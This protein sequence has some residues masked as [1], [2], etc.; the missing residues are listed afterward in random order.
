MA[1][2]VFIFKK[3]CDDTN[4]V[5]SV[6]IN[7]AHFKELTNHFIP[8]P[9][10]LNNTIEA[11]L[12]TMG[13]AARLHDP[14]PTFC[15]CRNSRNRNENPNFDSTNSNQQIIIADEVFQCPDCL[16]MFCLDC[17]LYVHETVHNCPGCV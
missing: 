9:P 16:N 13:F 8:P 12:M 10:I 7:E 14:T 17:D 5:F 4:G 11:H 1:A 2:E 3:V 15:S 6:A